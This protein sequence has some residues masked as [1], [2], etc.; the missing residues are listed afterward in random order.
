[1][2]GNFAMASKLFMQ[3]YVI[4]VGLDEGYVTT[5]YAFLS[6]KTKEHY[7]EMLRA[8]I[9]AAQIAGYKL[10]PSVIYT[11]CEMA[12]VKSVQ[13]V[14]DGN[15]SHKGCFFHLTQATWRKIQDIGL[16]TEYK[17]N[18]R[19]QHFTGM[20]DGLAFLPIHNISRVILYIE[21]NIPEVEGA[22]EL[23]NYFI[24]VYVRGTPRRINR[25][26]PNN[27]IIRLNAPQFP[28]Q[29]WNIFE[30]TLNMDERTNNICEG[31]NKF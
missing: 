13:E 31:W 28:P 2:D 5:V 17:E 9:D 8:V 21:Q 6:K 15:V 26:N 29:I 12:V 30:E 25:N 19:F 1:M 16:S 10:T 18:E 11:D 24:T 3:L 23:L 14:F 20:I 27:L 7:S 22:E 4:R